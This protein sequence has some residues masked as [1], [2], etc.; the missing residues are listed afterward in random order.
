MVDIII[1][2][3]AHVLLGSAV[4]Y[5]IYRN[6]QIKLTRLQSIL[7]LVIGGGAGIAPDITKWLLKD[8]IAHTLWFAPIL[9]LLIA[10]PFK[11]L[12]ALKWLWMGVTGSIIIGH[13]L[14]DLIDNG[15]AIFYPFIHREVGIALI[16]KDDLFIPLCLFIAVALSL[17]FYKN[18]KKIL[19]IGIAICFVYIT[20][21]SYLRMEVKK[22]ISVSYSLPDLRVTVFPNSSVWRPFTYSIKSEFFSIGGTSSINKNLAEEFNYFKI[23]WKV[24]KQYEE[25]EYHYIICES[26]IGGPKHSVFRSKNGEEWEEVEA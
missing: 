15:V 20:F 14:I 12:F 2:H 8:E 13:I 16:A 19:I 7:L 17:L 25:G 26:I 5:S 23:N 22:E 21:K 1:A 9:G 3:L 18:I 6:G 10:L 4:S 24:I 11:R